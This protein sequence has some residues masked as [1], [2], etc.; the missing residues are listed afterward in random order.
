M[1]DDHYSED[2][3]ERRMMLKKVREKKDL[4]KK[5]LEEYNKI[6]HNDLDSLIKIYKD[7]GGRKAVWELKGLGKNEIIKLIIIAEVS[8]INEEEIDDIIQK[9]LAKE[10]AEPEPEPEAEQ[11]GSAGGGGKKSKRRKSTRRK[12]TRRKSK[13]RKSKR[14]KTRRKK[15]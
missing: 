7:K 12:S 1:E 6:N 4:E 13:R 10:E 2:E 5:V 9:K 14:R 15:R 11:T 8:G 3:E